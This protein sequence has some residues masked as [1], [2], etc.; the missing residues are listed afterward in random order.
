MV[1]STAVGGGVAEILRR[2]VELLRA[3]DVDV[4]WEVMGGDDAFFEVTK[5][6]H[7]GLHG[8]RVELTREMR[9]AYARRTELEAGRLKLDGD[10]IMIHDPQPAGLAALRRRPG[11]TWIWRCHIDLSGPDPEVWRFL[12]PEVLRHDATIFSASEFVQQLAIPSYV[13][14]PSI[15]PFADKNRELSREETEEALKG[16]GVHGRTPLVSQVSRF[17]RLKDPVGVVQAFARV[18]RKT[19]AH[20]VLVGGSADDDPEGAAVLAETRE[21]ARNVPDVTILDLPNDS[22]VM[23]NAIQRESAVVLQKSLREGFALT[24]SEALWKERAVV[25][26]AVGGIPLQ[27]LHGRTGMLVHSV[28]G[29]AYQILRLLEYPGLRRRLGVAGRKHVLRRFLLPRET[30]DYLAVAV[31]ALARRTVIQGVSFDGVAGAYDSIGV[32]SRGVR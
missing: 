2:M 9:E 22:N 30:R 1:N 5:A 24:V 12:E 10:I 15:D 11:Q 20:L 23:I 26:S 18:R 8:R 13:A 16:L 7:N 4:E 29:A 27:V 32:S 28:D 19:R 31:S 25:A 3:L 17:D 6:I 14:P 21:A